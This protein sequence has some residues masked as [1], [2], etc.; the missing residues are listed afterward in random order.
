MG[1]L[2]GL[3]WVDAIVVLVIDLAR[4]VRRVSTPGR[5]WVEGKSRAWIAASWAL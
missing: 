3:L 2:G 5:G 4:V 1:E